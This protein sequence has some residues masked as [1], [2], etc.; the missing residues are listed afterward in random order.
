MDQSTRTA[1][2]HSWGWWSGGGCRLGDGRCI[3][4]LGEVTG[5]S[6]LRGR[7]LEVMERALRDDRVRVRHARVCVRERHV[8]VVAARFVRLEERLAPKDV[9][10]T[11]GEART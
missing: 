5:S 3:R 10:S 7:V 4:G 6:L 2:F 8:H 9:A 1:P 11:D